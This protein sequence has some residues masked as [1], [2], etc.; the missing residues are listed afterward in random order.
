MTRFLF[1]LLLIA[2]GIFGLVEHDAI[3]QEWSDMYPQ[4]PARQAALQHCSQEEG[5]FN[6]FSAA[7]RASCYQKYLQVELPV[8]S[9]GYSVQP[10]APTR[11]VPHAPTVRTNH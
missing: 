5:F 10:V 11:V 8:T 3:N 6:R 7:A 1:P 2:A 4:D 9:P